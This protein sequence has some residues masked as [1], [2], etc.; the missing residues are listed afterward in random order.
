MN[1]TFRTCEN[2]SEAASITFENMK[3]Y[4][5]RFAS[6]WDESKVF[7]VTSTLDNYDILLDN[8]V[9]GVMRLQFDEQYFLRDLQIVDGY[10]N[11]G[12][13]KAALDEAKRLAKLARGTML[14]LRVFK[15]SP[16]I[17]L[18]KRNGFMVNSEEERFINMRAK[19]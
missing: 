11:R 4:Y 19:I 5:Q 13:G 3:P 10:K 6:D 1:I 12:L 16:A 8:E 14:E 7:E 9:V 15:G 17:A 2:L 18:Y